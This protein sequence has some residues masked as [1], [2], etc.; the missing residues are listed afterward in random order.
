MKNKIRYYIKLKDEKK[1]RVT[2]ENFTQTS[3]ER[4]IASPTLELDCDVHPILFK[5]STLQEIKDKYLTQNK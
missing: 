2:V 3:S 5:I 4:I 1:R